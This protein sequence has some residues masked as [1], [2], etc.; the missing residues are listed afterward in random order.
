MWRETEKIWYT[1]VDSLPKLYKI[2]QKTSRSSSHQEW[3]KNKSL[4]VILR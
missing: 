1:K 2:F 3:K 4:K